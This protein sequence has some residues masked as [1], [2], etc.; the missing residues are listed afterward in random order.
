M[1]QR[2]TGI[3]FMISKKLMNSSHKSSTR[4]RGHDGVVLFPRY[5][6]STIEESEV[7]S[8]KRALAYV[9]HI[10]LCAKQDSV[11]QFS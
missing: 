2:S 5:I 3:N 1:M 7:K 4:V 10:V 8:P 9:L 11:A 6:L